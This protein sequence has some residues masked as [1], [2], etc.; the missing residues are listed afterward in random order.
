M[1]LFDVV[2]LTR[3]LPDEGLAAGSVGTIVHV[4]T[5]P[6]DAYEVE[7]TDGDGRTLASLAL[8]P[9]QIRPHR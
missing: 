2:E 3:E 1:D 6:R 5:K 9:D 8:T 7:F 4:F